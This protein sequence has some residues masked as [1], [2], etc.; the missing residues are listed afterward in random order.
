M[1]CKFCV[2]EHATA[3]LDVSYSKKLGFV[4]VN[5]DVIQNKTV[6]MVHNDT[7]SEV[8]KCE[9]ESEYPELLKGIGCMD[10]E[11][12]IKLKEDA[13]PHVEPI[14][15]VPHAMQE[16]PKME[17]D[18]LCKEGILHKVDIGEP[19]EWL[20]FFSVSRKPMVKLGYAWIQHI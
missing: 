1:I 11:I 8:F 6:K 10:A 14:R 17:L 13:I 15:H 18:K 4:K 5:F 16:L 12:S 3:I 2:V 7:L 20:N 19:I 9:M